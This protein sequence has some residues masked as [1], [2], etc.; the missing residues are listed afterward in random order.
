M[1]NIILKNKINNEL[2][3]KMRVIFADDEKPARDKLAH[4]LSLI[5]DI[6]VIGFATTGKEALELIN[7][8]S[9]I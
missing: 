4:Q 2:P 9:L 6:E 5:A 3:T 7:T 8:E 1:S